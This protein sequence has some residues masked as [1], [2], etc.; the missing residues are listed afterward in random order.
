[1]FED[2]EEEYQVAKTIMETQT[3]IIQ[4]PKVIY[5]ERQSESSR[6]RYTSLCGCTPLCRPCSSFRAPLSSLSLCVCQSR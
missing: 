4:V 2:R 3:R 1:M 5:E 6:A